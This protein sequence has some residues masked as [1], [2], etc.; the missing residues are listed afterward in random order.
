LKFQPEMKGIT[1]I[2]R[3]VNPKTPNAKRD[4]TSIVAWTYERKDGGRS[5]AFTGG[6][7]HVSFAEEGYR[8]LLTN[9]ILW[10]AKV[11]VPKFGANS[12]LMTNELH[13]YVDNRSMPKDK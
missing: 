1:P 4:D 10:T 6:H 2:L 13:G 5:F 7:L 8:R 9:A 3:T 11:D 12:A